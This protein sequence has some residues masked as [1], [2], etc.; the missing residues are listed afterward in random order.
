MQ[1]YI[2]DKNYEQ[3]A[4]IDQADSILWHK[5][6]NDAGECEIY[7]PCDNEA[8]SVLQTGYYVYRYDDDMFCQI[9]KI[10]IETDVEKGN[11]IIATAPDISTRLSGRI[12]RWQIVF[13]GTV[14]EF[15]NKV[16]TDNVVNPAQTQRKIDNFEIDTSNFSEFTETIEVSTFTEDLLSLITST[17]KAYNLGF[18]VS[19]NINTQKLVFRLFRGGNKATTTS[20]QYIE[21]SPTYANILSTEY[22]L[23]E[24]KYKNMVYVGYKAKDSDTIHLLSMFNGSEEP[25]GE[26]RKEIYI[27]GT[28]TSRDITYNELKIMFPSLQ[29]NPAT[30]GSE[31]AGYYYI[32]TNGTQE[33]VATFEITTTDNV[34]EEKITVTD[35]TY[36]LLIRSLGNAALTEHIVTQEFSGEVDTIDTYEY[37]KDYDLGDIVKVV[38][39]YGISAN[40]QITEIMESDDVEDGKVIEPKFEFKGGI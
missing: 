18:R 28:G 23:D 33:Q 24:S 12:V 35:Y 27:D 10:E 38:N 16:L 26:N 34:K 14:A 15:I 31:T 7:L 36:L 19:F 9:K 1:L 11:Y 30:Q 5:K 2:L 40:A 17:C 4:L 13:S 39:E 20:D 32:T 25:Q 6:Y 22:K 37:K 8:L 29:R 3:V 21:F